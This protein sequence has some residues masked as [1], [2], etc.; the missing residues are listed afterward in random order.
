MPDPL[1]QP[2][3]EATDAVAWAPTD[4]VRDRARLRTRRSRVAAVAA[5]AVTV[6]LIVGGVA[7]TRQPRANPVTPPPATSTPPPATSA[8]PPATSAPPP[9]TSAPVP[10]PTVITDA[11]FLQPEDV[12]PGY[13]GAP[14][15]DS[16]GDWTFDFT[17]SALGCP[18]PG[19][20]TA[21][22]ARRDWR[23]RRDTPGSEDFVTQYVAAFSP[24][25]AARY[26]DE[27]RARVA[28]CRAPERG[29][30]IA[31]RAERFA[32][33][34]SLLIEADFGGGSMTKLVLVR[35]GDLFTEF[36][37]RPERDRAEAEALGRK[38]ALR[39]R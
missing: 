22:T 5:T 32:G 18:P 7:A 25:D 10:A 14:D 6:C 35:Q 33:E 3:F 19:L 31:I 15:D 38:A 27:I 12:G 9:P 2:L 16:S 8:P 39:L 20:F 24:G 36:F 30:S 4:V 11:M 26:L 28:A 13:Q 29:G 23:L 17:T 37:G 34:D 1:F 21:P